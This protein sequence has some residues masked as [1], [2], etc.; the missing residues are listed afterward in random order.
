MA[1]VVFRIKGRFASPLARGAIPYVGPLQLSGAA[2]QSSTKF[3]RKIVHVRERKKRARRKKRVA[4]VEAPRRLGRKTF[5]SR[6]R[7]PFKKFLKPVQGVNRRQRA[8]FFALVEVTF[9]FYKGSPTYI[10]PVNMGEMS[11]AAGR[12]I[13]REEVDEAV[14]VKPWGGRVGE[15]LGVYALRTKGE[16]KKLAPALRR[17]KGREK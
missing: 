7:S 6:Y 13:T 1:R 15:I 5:P 10:L 12:A 16:R 3:R 8:R 9:E 11:G 14:A 17:A 2:R 4:K